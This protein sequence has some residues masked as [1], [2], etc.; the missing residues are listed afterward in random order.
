ML[1]LWRYLCLLLTVWFLCNFGPVYVVRAQ[2]RTGATTH[3]DEALA[4][5]SIFAA[6][7]IRAPREWNISGELCS[8]AAI[9]ASVLDSNPAYNPLIKCDCSFENSSISGF[10]LRNTQASESF[11]SFVA[12]RSEISPRNNDARPMLGAQMNEGR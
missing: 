3:P 6:W 10:P 5:N 9:D 2:N 7:R 1:R 4:L 8:G 12:P 11:T